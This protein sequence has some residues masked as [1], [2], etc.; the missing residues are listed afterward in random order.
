LDG[1]A[2][3]H[4]RPRTVRD[5]WLLGALFDASLVDPVPIFCNQLV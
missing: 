2:L 5:W 3:H 1:L 4:L